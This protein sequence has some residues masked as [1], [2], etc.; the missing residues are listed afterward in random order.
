MLH[1]RSPIVRGLAVVLVLLCTLWGGLAAAQSI[2]GTTLVKNVSASSSQTASGQRAV[3]NSTNGQPVVGVS[4][5]SRLT[6]QAGFWAAD[7]QTL[8]D[9]QD[10]DRTDT[11]IVFVP[12]MRQ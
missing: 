11:R 9:P 12:L 6:L 4:A 10:P 8:I 1:T 5:T 2:S 7:R 3:L